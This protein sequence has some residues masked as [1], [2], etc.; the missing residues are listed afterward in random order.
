MDRAQTKTGANQTPLTNLTAIGRCEAET[1][2]SRFYTRDGRLL[3]YSTGQRAPAWLYTSYRVYLAAA[4]I[5][6]LPRSAPLARGEPISAIIRHV[7]PPVEAAEPDSQTPGSRFFPEGR[8][9][10]GTECK[11][12]LICRPGRQRVTALCRLCSSC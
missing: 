11:S 4:G 3:R 1:G 2:F 12:F 6:N 9:G 8:S 10:L 5:S 7:T